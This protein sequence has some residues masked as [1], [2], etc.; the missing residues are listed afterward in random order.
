M[1]LPNDRRYSTEHV[2]ALLDS[3]ELVIGITDYAQ[4]ALGSVVSLYLP[5]KGQS[6]IA[7]DTCGTVESMKTASDLIAPLNATVVD[8]NESVDIDP[9][10][11][12]DDP[13]EAG[14]LLRL[15]DFDMEAYHGLLDAASYEDMTTGD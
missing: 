8:L 6:V 7:G 12:N 14:W 3:D 1:Q 9:E 5:V 10:M 11:I 4:T 13:Y 2:W 15:K